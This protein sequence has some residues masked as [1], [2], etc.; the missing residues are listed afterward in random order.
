MKLAFAAALAFFVLNFALGMSLQL[1][2]KFHV[3]PLHHALYFLTC[4]ST[5]ACALFASLASR[6]WWWPAL[7]LGALLLVP[8]TK[9]GRGDHALL[10]C[11]VGVGFAFT[12]ARLS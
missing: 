2:A 8:S 7:L 11:L 4:A 12:S 6:A 9:P 1:G 5:F 3:R 10:A